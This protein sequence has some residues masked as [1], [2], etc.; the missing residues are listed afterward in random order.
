MESIHTNYFVFLLHKNVYSKIEQ[1][2]TNDKDK[3]DL[4]WY[5]K[6]YNYD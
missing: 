4:E 6:F 3:K 2:I 5:L 1:N